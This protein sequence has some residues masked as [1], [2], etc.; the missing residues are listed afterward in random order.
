MERQLW[1]Q[2]IE[3]LAQ[4]RVVRKPRCKFSDA[5]VV[6]VY[7]WAVLHDRPIYWACCQE[8]WPIYERRHALPSPSTMTRRLRLDTVKILIARIEEL[9][10]RSAAEP[11]L[12]VAVDGK[13][14]VISRHSKDRQ[15]G[16]GQAAGGKAK[17]YKLHTVRGSDGSILAWRIAPMNRDERVM[18]RRLLRT[19]SAKR[20]V[21]ADSHYDDKALYAICEQR[22]LQLVAPRKL[23][24]AGL[25]H[26]PQSKSRLFCIEL[27]ENPQPNFGE[28]LL[29]DRR[30]IE[31]Y[32]GNLTS[33]G[34]GLVCLPPWVRTYKRVRAWVQAK[35]ILRGLRQAWHT[36]TCI[37]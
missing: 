8:N 22:G 16:Y 9:V 27:L 34:G 4:L 17:G 3:I 13:P 32:F 25:G 5:E 28:A 36:E 15:S 14:L 12:V 29:H 23:P 2:L 21:V 26:R 1:C 31:G 6:R 20:Y 19:V 24:G 11:P 33:F 7:F 37:A 18:A 30:A 35:L 10:L